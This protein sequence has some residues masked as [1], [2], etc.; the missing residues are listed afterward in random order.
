MKFITPNPFTTPGVLSL[1]DAAKPN[2]VAPLSA[3]ALAL[4]WRND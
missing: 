3:G 2:G 4:V 1:T